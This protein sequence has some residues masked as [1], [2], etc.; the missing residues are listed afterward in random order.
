MIKWLRNW[1]SGSRNWKEVERFDP[2]W[3]ERISLM[4]RHIAA[5]DGTVADLGCG[6]MWLR[7]YLPPGVRYIG[8]DYRDRG[9]GCIVCN[10]DTDEFPEL[11]AQVYFVSGC[12][13]Y[14]SNPDAFIRSLATRGSKCIVSYCGLEHFG[15]RRQRDRRG[16]KNHLLNSEIAEIFARYGMQ[17][18][19]T[20]LTSTN[21]A[22][23][24]FARGPRSAAT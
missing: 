19:A 9:D 15:D 10:L 2:A 24:V 16:W 5:N 4:A 8:V 11:D 1:F 13:E 22:V 17:P 14:M 18:L 7:E 21:N 23:F 6:P 3:R 20:E 12:L